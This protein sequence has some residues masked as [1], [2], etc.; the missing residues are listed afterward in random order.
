MAKRR[1]MTTD[2]SVDVSDELDVGI[3]PLRRR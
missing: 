1:V 2:V 3:D